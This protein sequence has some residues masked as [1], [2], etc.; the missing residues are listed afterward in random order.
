MPT[1]PEMTDDSLRDAVNELPDN[2][3]VVFEDIDS[4]FAKDRSNKVSKS[5]LTFSGLLN[6]LDGIGNPNRQIF[7]LTTN[8]REQLDSALIRNGRVD[9]H[10][11]FNYAVEEQMVQMWSNFYPDNKD[12]SSLFASS[13]AEKLVT[14]DLKVTA[15][16][17]QHF[18]VT[19]MEATA[20][21]ALASVDNIIADIKEH[22]AENNSKLSKS[23]EEK[24]K[25]DDEEDNKSKKIKINSTSN[26]FTTV[27]YVTAFFALTALHSKFK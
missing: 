18:F 25:N 9:L 26:L 10:V 17:L 19:Q 12:M 24:I 7:I 5:S 4:L 3:I 22:N 13:L 8:L 11:E 14:N 23:E 20:E 2:A 27:C 21:Q 15:S 1:H 6:A 16:G